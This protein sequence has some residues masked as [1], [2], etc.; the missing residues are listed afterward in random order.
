VTF[1]RNVAAEAQGKMKRVEIVAIRGGGGGWRGCR[2]DHQSGRACTVN[3]HLLS[4]LEYIERL[5]RECSD[6]L[7]DL[8][9]SGETQP[10]KKEESCCCEARGEGR[11]SLPNWTWEK[12]PHDRQQGATSRRSSSGENRRCI[13]RLKRNARL[14][15]TLGVR[16]FGI[17]AVKSKDGGQKK[18][19]R[20]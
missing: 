2:C 12:G 10:A 19:A 11:A 17:A 9:A 15:E 5:R 4:T 14:K 18:A 1:Q 13:M 16:G 6:K 3:C 20:A 7:T 8:R